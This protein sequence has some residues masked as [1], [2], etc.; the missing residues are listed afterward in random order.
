VIIVYGAPP[1]PV[2]R[3]DVAVHLGAG[4]G[5]VMRYENLILHLIDHLL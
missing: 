2:L 4:G 1:D 5:E 3:V